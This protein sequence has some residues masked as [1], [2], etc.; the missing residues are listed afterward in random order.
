[1][2]SIDDSKLNFKSFQSF[3]STKREGT[4]MCNTLTDRITI[5]AI[6]KPVINGKSILGESI[7]IGRNPNSQLGGNSIIVR[8]SE[9][10]S[11]SKTKPTETHCSSFNQEEKPS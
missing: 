5:D 7:G 8:E 2:S 3:P 10:L 6:G 11:Q 4:S 1:M 9:S